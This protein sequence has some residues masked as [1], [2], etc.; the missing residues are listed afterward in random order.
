MGSVAAFHM[1]NA[2]KKVILIEKKFVGWASSGVN[3]GGVRRQGR[4][5]A[6]LPLAQESLKDWMEIRSLVGTDCGFTVCDNLRVAES[7]EQMEQISAAIPYHTEAGV[8]L[9]PLDRSQM[10][11]I[12]S[13]FGKQVIGGTICRGDGQA[14]PRLVSP[15]FARMAREKGAIVREREGVVEVEC[16]GG[17]VEAVQTEKGR[18]RGEVFVNVSGAWGPQLA[19]MA[20]DQVKVGFRLPQMM[21]TEKFRPLLEPVLGFAGRKLSFKQVPEGNLV[22]G[23]GRPGI[24]GPREMRKDLQHE[25]MAGAARDVIEV[26]PVLKKVRIIRAWVGIE[27]EPDDK[28]PVIDRSPSRENLIHAFGFSGHGFQLGLCVGR[29]LAEWIIHGEPFLPIEAFNIRRVIVN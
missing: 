8:T 6:E 11:R 14:N 15:A 24:G 20:G 7:E 4:H 19:E 10:K 1:A 16:I 12:C 2:G 13:D 18:Y 3:A 23:G 17:R 28:I 25:M 29:L 27:G 21:V 26:F 22:I 9:E 5:P